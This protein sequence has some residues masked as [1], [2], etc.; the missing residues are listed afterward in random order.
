MG[1]AQD[2]LGVRRQARWSYYRSRYRRDRCPTYFYVSYSKQQ[3]K[4]MQN[5]RR[6]WLGM[7]ERLTIKGSPSMAYTDISFVV[8]QQ[9]RMISVKFDVSGTIKNF[10]ASP[11]RREYDM[12]EVIYF[13]EILNMFRE[14]DCTRA[15]DASRGKYI[16]AVAQDHSMS[17]SSPARA[18]FPT[19]ELPVEQQLD[20]L[21]DMNDRLWPP[22]PVTSLP[23]STKPPIAWRDK[24]PTKIWIVGCVAYQDTFGEMHHTK[25]LYQSV[26]PE[27]APKIPEDAD[28]SN[29][30]IPFTDFVML[31]SE[32]D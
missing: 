23:A 26:I 20:L 10:G 32:S 16:G 2:C 13:G 15:E 12:F 4:E 3:W 29:T 25:L 1:A 9:A 28:L 22:I 31:D 11:A 19:V 24:I 17:I 5:A 8:G 6:P 18:I 30:H 27:N 21:I 14:E 7:S